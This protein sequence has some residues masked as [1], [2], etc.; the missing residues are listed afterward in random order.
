MW[1]SEKVKECERKTGRACTMYVRKSIDFRV[2]SG[3]FIC[4]QWHFSDATLNLSGEF[5]LCAVIYTEIKAIS[6][7]WQRIYPIQSTYAVFTRRRKWMHTQTSPFIRRANRHNER[8]RSI[9]RIWA[10]NH[11][12]HVFAKASDDTRIFGKCLKISKFSLCVC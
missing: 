12:M 2:H 6:S 9:E 11:V 5:S 10:M 4:L 7:N 1:K 8:V 3:H